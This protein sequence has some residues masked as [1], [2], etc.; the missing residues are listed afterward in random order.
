MRTNSKKDILMSNYI[1]LLPAVLLVFNVGYSA[2]GV[3]VQTMQQ[4]P[5]QGPLQHDAKKLQQ[6]NTSNTLQQSETTQY[7]RSKT[8]PSLHTTLLQQNSNTIAQQSIPLANMNQLNT[9]S[10]PQST[11]TPQSNIITQPKSIPNSVNPANNSNNLIQR[12]NS[13]NGTSNSAYSLENIAKNQLLNRNHTVS[14][15]NNITQTTQM[16]HVLNNNNVPV[17][18]NSNT[19]QKAQQFPT[20][21][22]ASVIQQTS[23]AVTTQE[24]LNMANKMKWQASILPTLEQQLEGNFIDTQQLNNITNK[25]KNLLSNIEQINKTDLIY[26]ISLNSNQKKILEHFSA[27]TFNTIKALSKSFTNIGRS[28]TNEN[29]MQLLNSFRIQFIDNLIKI[30]PEDAKTSKLI[31]DTYNNMVTKTIPIT[32]DSTIKHKSS[33]SNKLNKEQKTIAILQQLL[34]WFFNIPKDL[35]TFIKEIERFYSSFPAFAV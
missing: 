10:V 28:K 14:G 35:D 16:N 18:I 4:Q 3:Q 24:E 11:L 8:M 30:L 9:A 17:N 34:E 27:T 25:T 31:I 2:P 23:N 33:T 15:T 19:V 12:T 22:T 7:L 13:Y 6:N 20:S 29:I 21:N 5:V 32:L 26:Q 1:K